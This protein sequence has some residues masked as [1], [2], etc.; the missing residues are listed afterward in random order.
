MFK[1]ICSLFCSNKRQFEGEYGKL[2]ADMSFEE[3]Q[4]TKK[5]LINEPF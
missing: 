1:F 2:Y 4:C 3:Y 5:Y